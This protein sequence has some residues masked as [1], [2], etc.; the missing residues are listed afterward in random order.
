MCCGRG[1]K[2]SEPLHFWRVLR[3]HGSSRST[4]HSLSDKQFSLECDLGVSS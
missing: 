3:G 1:M 2:G 4:E